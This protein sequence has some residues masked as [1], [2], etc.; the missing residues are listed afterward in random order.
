MGAELSISVSAPPEVRVS[1][2]ARIEGLVAAH[3][4]RVW[5]TLRRLGLP[6]DAADDAAQQVFAAA[7]KKIDVIELGSELRYLLGIT[8][9]VAAEAKRVYARRREFVGQ[10]AALEGA[11]ANAPLPDELL[12]RKR[13]RALFDEA[14]ASMPNDLRV[15]F[16]FFEI[17]GMSAPEIGEVL[18][19]PVGT[20]ASRLRRA[21]EQFR[22]F[23]A[24]FDRARRHA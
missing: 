23:A 10:D 19:I 13:A 5:R 8:V 7:A 14:L 24:R 20:V 1:S 12:D 3:F 6:D 16:V 2:R 17:D 9:R 4:D 18:G 11:V 15:V 22:D 21:R